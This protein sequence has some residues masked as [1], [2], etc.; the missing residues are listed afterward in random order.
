MTNITLA[1]SY[2]IKA[3]KRLK[4][5]TVLLDEKAYSDVVRE[6]QE[7][8]ELSLKGMLRNVGIEP[9]KWH[10]VGKIVQQYRDRFR[11]DTVPHVDRLADISAWLRK[12]REFSFYG[13][14]D[15]IP[16]E[17]YQI[18]DAMRAI[19]DARFVVS[20]AEREIQLS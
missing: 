8:V 18:E 5:L 14:I 15:F 12:E 17:E 13:D 20:V 19:E 16:T 11:K 9:P 7:I 4:I 1:Q 10:D 6:A 2:L 3:L